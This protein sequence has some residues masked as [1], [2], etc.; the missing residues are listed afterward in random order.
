MFE[1]VKLT[2]LALQDKSCE[3]EW[4]HSIILRT[5]ESLS[6]KTATCSYRE[7]FLVFNPRSS[8]I[9]ESHSGY[10]E[11]WVGDKDFCY[12]IEI[13]GQIKK[14]TAKQYE[15]I[16]IPLGKKHKIINPHDSELNIFEVQLGNIRADD[17]VQYAKEDKRYN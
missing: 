13:D 12:V 17:K 7:K 9:L 15:R 3:R 4:G 1:T 8:I 14:R 11:V 16:Y 2:A 6:G 5:D 10:C